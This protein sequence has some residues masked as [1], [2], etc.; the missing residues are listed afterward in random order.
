MKLVKPF[1]LEKKQK[2]MQKTV[3][4]SGFF[5]L[6]LRMATEK[7]NNVP[8]RPVD[9]IFD[10]RR[11]AIASLKCVACNGPASRFR[12]ELSKREFQLSGLCQRCQDKVFGL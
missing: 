12:D 4:Q 11:E 2:Q 10:G 3:D 1:P 5:V 7:S 9:L 8:A 6:H